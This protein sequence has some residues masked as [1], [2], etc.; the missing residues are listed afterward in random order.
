M[1]DDNQR[2]IELRDTKTRLEETILELSVAKRRMDAVIKS[3]LDCIICM[4]FDGLVTEFNPAAERTFGYA[5]Q[6][7]IGRD[8]HPL[9]SP[10]GTVRLIPMG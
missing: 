2:D 1:S 7:V 4:D 9:L 8:Y 10:P 3:S 5:R 6:D